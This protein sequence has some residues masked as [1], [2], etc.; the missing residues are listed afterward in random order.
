MR[1]V[2]AI[3]VSGV[4]LASC[5]SATPGRTDRDARGSETAD[6]P[7]AAPIQPT[8]KKL[9]GFLV[10]DAECLSSGGKDAAARMPRG[11]ELAIGAT[12]AARIVDASPDARS[13]LRGWGESIAVKGDRIEIIP[14]LDETW[15]DGTGA[16][17][18]VG[19]V[20]LCV[21]AAPAIEGRDV[22]KA[23]RHRAP[24]TANRWLV[25]VGL[26]DD[27]VARMAKESKGRKRILFLAD[28]TEFLGVFELK[29]LLAQKGVTVGFARAPGHIEGG[30]DVD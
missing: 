18:Q 23:R 26:S 13:R 28:N 6:A 8:T 22:A 11:I 17:T 21:D 1:R 5:A 14:L 25:D 15:L 12:H 27:A 2:A 24:T 16:P 19:W 7:S 20:A 29:D 4:L 3:G 30:P 10:D 9:E